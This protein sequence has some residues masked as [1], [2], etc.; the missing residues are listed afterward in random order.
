MANVFTSVTQGASNSTYGGNVPQSVQGP[1]HARTRTTYATV[2]AAPTTSDT[3]IVALLKSSDR[4][5][6]IK[7]A[8]DGAAT[9]GALNI[10]LASADL[11]NDSISLTV[12]DEDLF[13]SAQSVVTAIAFDAAGS[14]FDEA[15]T[16]DDVM[17]RGKTLWELA[18]LGAASYTEDPGLTFAITADPSTTV[19]AATEMGFL[20]TYVAGD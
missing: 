1:A 6:D 5:I 14:V 17:D 15:G 2:D 20:I 8:T 9:A 13:A 12:I 4:L 10:G 7:L 19:N 3:V 18:A 16:L 11:S